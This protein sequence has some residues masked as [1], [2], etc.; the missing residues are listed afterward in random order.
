M[1]WFNEYLFPSDMSFPPEIKE[2]ALVACGRFCCLCHK[3]C[4]IK[5][6]VHH[7]IPAFKGG[8]NNFDNA[9]PLCFDCHSDML[10]YDPTHPKGN[11]FSSSELIQ[12]RDRWY[13]KVKGKVNLADIKS[14]NDTDKKIYMKL[15]KEFP[16]YWITD[17]IQGESEFLLRGLDNFL[18]SCKNPAFEFIDPDL[19]SLRSDLMRAALVF[20]QLEQEIETQIQ[21]LQIKAQEISV[22]YG[23]LIRSGTRKLGILPPEFGQI[24]YLQ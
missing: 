10:S 4:G 22:V 21:D 24:D 6:E 2:K 23:T 13:E 20:M 3:F 12:H 17:Y 15:L 8:T 7:I 1:K 19:E 5:I 16:F 18:S 11:T 9:I 14:A